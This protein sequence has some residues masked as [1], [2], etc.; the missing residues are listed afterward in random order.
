MLADPLWSL[1]DRIGSI[2]AELEI[3]VHEASFD[4][5]F[6]MLADRM[7]G[8]YRFILRRSAH[9]LN[10]R[11]RD[12][13]LVSVRTL[14]ARGRSGLLACA[15]FLE[16]GNDVI[17]VD[18]FGDRES[19]SLHHLLTALVRKLRCEKK[20]PTDL[21]YVVGW[22]FGSDSDRRL[23][24]PQGIRSGYPARPRGLRVHE[25]LARRRQLHSGTGGS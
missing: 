2:P 12:N 8:Q 17:L 9:Y 6:T 16:E 22:F 20:E 5:E 18:L 13:P 10:W 3:R 19:G 4:D 15:I 23:L 14:T 11:Y 1:S 21:L 25:N 24:P 7:S